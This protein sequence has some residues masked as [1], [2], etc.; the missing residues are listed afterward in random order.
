MAVIARTARQ[1]N[2]V[3]EEIQ[4]LG[5]RCLAVPADISYE[6]DIS[7]AFKHI[8]DDLG[9]I[10]ILVK[11][12]YSPGYWLQLKVS[13]NSELEELDQFLRDIWLECCGHMSAFSYQRNELKMGRKLK[14]VLSPGMEL[15]HEYDFGSTTELLVKVLAEYEGP[16]EKNKPVEILA[17]NEAPEIPCDECG[18]ALAVQICTE[19]QWDGSG[20]LCE[21]CAKKHEC[22]EEMMLPVVNSPRT[23]VCGYEG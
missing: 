21:A 17:R 6:K 22:G 12:S 20:W 13:S 2:H 16:M 7:Y 14:D 18:K 4:Q 15:L 1:I 8:H 5:R 11:G 9:R 3:A 23:G 19:C 10:D